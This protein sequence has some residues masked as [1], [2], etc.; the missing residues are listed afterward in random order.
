MGQGRLAEPVGNSRFHSNGFD[1]AAEAAFPQ[2]PAAGEY[3]RRSPASVPDAIGG[4]NAA[5]PPGAGPRWCPMRAV[6]YE[7]R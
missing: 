5:R 2:F 3:T 4:W 1:A 7:L 6:D